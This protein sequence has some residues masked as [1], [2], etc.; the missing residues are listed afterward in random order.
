MATGSG[1]GAAIQ[2]P[3]AAGGY[4]TFRGKPAGS[5]PAA[6]RGTRRVYTGARL[7]EVRTKATTASGAGAF[8]HR[9]LGGGHSAGPGTGILAGSSAVSDVAIVRGH[10]APV[11]VRCRP[12]PVCQG[13][14]VLRGLPCWRGILSRKPA[15]P[16]GAGSGTAISC[17]ALSN[18]SPYFLR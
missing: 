10:R 17:S 6:N 12:L 15:I 18:R 7:E 13:T 2:L 14:S 1:A 16:A 3:H 5:S 8:I 11:Q 4:F 9:S